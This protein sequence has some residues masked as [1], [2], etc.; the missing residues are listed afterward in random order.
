[1]SMSPRA[2]TPKL[3]SIKKELKI[4]RRSRD[5]RAKKYTN[6]ICSRDNQIHYIHPYACFLIIGACMIVI[7][8]LLLR[9][10]SK[11]RDV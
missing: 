8:L 10:A 5:G 3:T 2:V 6:K 11:R 9:K 4:K 1:M 7:I